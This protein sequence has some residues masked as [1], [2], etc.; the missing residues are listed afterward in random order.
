MY[1]LHLPTYLNLVSKTEVINELHSFEQPGENQD[2]L[3]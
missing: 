1:C 2:L 3:T